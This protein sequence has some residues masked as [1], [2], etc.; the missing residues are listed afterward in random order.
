MISLKRKRFGGH[1]T[2]CRLNEKRFGFI[3]PEH[4]EK[5]I[6][7]HAN[8]CTGANF[9]DLREGDKVGFDIIA[10]SKGLNAVNVIRNG[11]PPEEEVIVNDETDGNADVRIAIETVSRRLAEI[12]A[13]EPNAL[14]ELE[15]RDL[16][17]VI[18]EVFSGLGFDAELTPGSKDG[19]KDVVISYSKFNETKSYLV[20][21]KHWRSGKRV[22]RGSVLEF[23]HVIAR[24][25]TC[26]GILLASS[27]FTHGAIEG[28]TEI[29]RKQV[30]FGTGEKIIGL[31]RAYIKAREGVWYPPDHLDAV[32]FEKTH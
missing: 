8:E 13:K 22:P 10:G 18:A 31:C 24:E 1:G 25:N 6:F 7:F 2:I 27:G 26:G 28:L 15:W 4:S 3:M 32:I 9:E 29:E 17:R 21:I 5:D 11:Y 30:G 12:I 23:L 19:G 16:E 20:E 14:N